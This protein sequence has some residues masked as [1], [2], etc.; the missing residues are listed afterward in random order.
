MSSH[1]FSN[2]FHSSTTTTTPNSSTTTLLDSIVATPK[3]Q[4]TACICTHC[5]HLLT[6]N[7]AGHGVEQGTNSNN[8]NNNVQ[9]HHHQL[10]QG[11]RWSPTPIQLLVLEE[12]YRQGTKT[13]SAEQ[14]QQIASQLRRFGKIEGKNVFYW[15]Q[16]HKARERQKRRRREMEETTAAASAKGLKETGCEVKETKKWAST[17]NCN[18]GGGHA[19]Q[20]SMTAVDISEK[21]SNGWNEFEERVLRRNRSERQAKYFNIPS[22]NIAATASV[23]SQIT[24]NIQLLSTHHH[25][26]HHNYNKQDNTSSHPRTL[27]LFPIH[28]NHDDDDDIISFSDRKSNKLCANASMEEA[29]SCDQFFEFLPLRN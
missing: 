22:I 20:E 24:H 14:I 12:L 8:N 27:E 28:K 9:S 19:V 25:P 11:T 18:G 10:Q 21:E 1:S 4:L 2:L 23:A 15:F 17:S 26:Q 5:N 6:F 16:N 3:Q 13:P 7:P 29:L